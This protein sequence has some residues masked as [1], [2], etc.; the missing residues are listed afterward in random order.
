MAYSDSRGA[1]R[2]IVMGTVAMAIV[3]TAANV[4][5]RYPI[6]NW[7]TWGAFVYPLSFLVTDLTNRRLGPQQARRV[8]YAGFFFALWLSLFLATPRIAA[9]SLS[10]FLVAQL[11][12]VHIFDRLRR[13]KWWRAP[14]VSSSTASALD[15][16]VFFTLAFAGTGLPWVT[17]GLGAYVVKLGMA[18]LLLLPFRVLL[19]ATRPTLEPAVDS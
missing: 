4:L 3:V 16:V 8:V 10:A 18:L 14:F 1:F 17:W 11:L 7:M 9:A 5:V 13:A 19:D 2:A 15:T 6:N 12:D